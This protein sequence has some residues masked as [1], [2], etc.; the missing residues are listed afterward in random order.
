[1]TAE[2]YQRPGLYQKI[3]TISLMPIQYHFKQ[4]ILN[5]AKKKKKKKK[6]EKTLT[7]VWP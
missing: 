5:R 2:A 6:K 4:H 3:P 7:K 1:M